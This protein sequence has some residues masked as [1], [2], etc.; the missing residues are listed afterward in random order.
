MT[1]TNIKVPLSYILLGL[2]LSFSTVAEIQYLY[3]IH[4]VYEDNGKSLLNPFRGYTS[5]IKHSYTGY[6]AQQNQC[7][8]EAVRLAFNYKCLSKTDHL[9][10][11]VKEVTK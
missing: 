1:M 10:Q 9:I 3:K 8:L 11:Q 6:K 2:T 7:A 4:R 5:Y